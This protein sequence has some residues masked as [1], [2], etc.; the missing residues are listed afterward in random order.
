M[1]CLYDEKIDEGT[2]VR[3]RLIFEPTLKEILDKFD[4]PTNEVGKNKTA[5]ASKY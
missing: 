3:L 4:G 1:S 5:N 2:Y